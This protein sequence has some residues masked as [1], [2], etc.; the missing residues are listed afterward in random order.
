MFSNIALRSVLKASTDVLRE[1]GVLSKLAGSCSAV[2]AKNWTCSSAV[3][4][5]P[6]VGCGK[7]SHKQIKPEQMYV[8]MSVDMKYIAMST[9]TGVGALLFHIYCCIQVLVPSSEVVFTT[10]DSLL[11]EPMHYG[12]KMFPVWANYIRI[13]ST[14]NKMKP[15]I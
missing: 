2:A 11:K 5:G 15:L 12:N 1:S 9:A 8:S 7:F 3:I 10:L 4:S 6:R 13:L 14:N